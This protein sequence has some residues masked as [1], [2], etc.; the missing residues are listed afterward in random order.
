VSDLAWER[1]GDEFV[2]TWPRDSFEITVRRIREDRQGDVIAEIQA[3]EI[4]A[5]EPVEISAPTKCNLSSSRSKSDAVRALN[6]RR[7]SDGGNPEELLPDRFLW[8]DAIEEVASVVLREWRRG[9]PIVD[10][11]AVDVP[12]SLPYLIYPYLPLNE[13]TVFF[14]DGSSGK[15]LHV[16]MLAIAVRLGL[17]IPH[18]RAPEVQGNVLYLDYETHDQGQARRLS[19]VARGFGLGERPPILYRRMTHAIMD[20]AAL[21]ATE[22]RRRN[23]VFVIVDSLAWACGADP[24]EAGVAIAAMA[25][26]RSLGVTAGVIAHIAKGERENKGKRSVLGSVFFENGVRSA[27]EVRASKAQAGQLRQAFYHRKANDDEL[28]MYP[29]GQIMEFGQTEGQKFVSFRSDDISASD[30]LASGTGLPARIRQ[31]LG[32][33]TRPATTAELALWL[34][35]RDQSIR[36]TLNRMGDDVINLAERGQTGRW[37]LRGR[38]FP[39]AQPKASAKLPES[40]DEDLEMCKGCNRSAPVHRYRADGGPLC[41]SCSALAE[42]EEGV[43][44][45]TQP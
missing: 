18:C 13:S 34:D 1:A 24:N 45:V 36:T 41:I 16:M 33:A 38:E 26:I 29:L 5:A 22:I 10:L 9:E 28:A 25:A 14:G 32:S 15:S 37:A 35:A 12:D 8:A 42:S 7:N 44:H 31:A 23:V 21:L 4:I 30:E 11:S 27:W 20:D 2:F 40:R 17:K 39:A 43:Q 6:A 3:S 19:H